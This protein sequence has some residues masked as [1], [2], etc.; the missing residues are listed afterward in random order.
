MSTLFKRIFDST[1]DGLL[2]VDQQGKITELNAQTLRLFGYSREELLHQPIELL[3]SAAK[4]KHHEAHRNNYLNSP[5]RRPMGENSELFA[6]RKDGSEFPVDIQLSPIDNNNETA[7]LCVVRDVS[8]RK[9]AESKFRGLLESAPDAIVIVNEYGEITLINSQTEK[10]FGYSREELLNRS[11]DILVPG[12]FREHHHEHRQGYFKQSN[13]RP[14]GSGL[15]LYGLRKDGSEFAIEIS[16]SPLET[17]EGRLVSAA[18]RDITA[19]KNAEQVIKDSLHEKE[20]MLKEIHHRV[21][22]NLAVIGS[23]FYLQS[24]Y[25]DNEQLKEIL[26]KSQDR[27]RSMA[28][29]HESLYRSDKFQEINFSDY[30][31]KIAPQLINTYTINEIKPNLILELEDTFLDIESAI[32][33]GLIL[34]EILTNTLKHAFLS[35]SKKNEVLIR[36]KKL[37]NNRTHIEINDNGVGLPENTESNTSNSLGLR[38]IHSLSRQLD[39]QFSMKSLATGTQATLII[40]EKITTTESVERP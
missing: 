16:L 7:I 32:P 34:N 31:K 15:D 33:C 25:T 14:M 18:I 9:Q 17:V 27:V 37:A 13:V 40:P 29:V 11:V 30:I 22:N 1:P 2:V 38:L 6:K 39:G 5:S 8:E 28:M 20:I 10:L 21:K 23:L 19:R 36:V 26:Q 3:V 24:T 35:S 12:R 4:I